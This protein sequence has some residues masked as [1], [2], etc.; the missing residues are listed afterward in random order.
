MFN[1]TSLT[2]LTVMTALVFTA[3]PA[4]GQVAP[5]TGSPCYDGSFQSGID[6]AQSTLPLA[7]NLSIADIILRIIAVILDVIL[8]IA[9]L[10][11]IIAGVYLIMSGGD[12]GQKDKAKKIIIYV[13]AGIIV[14]LFA[15]AIVIFVNNAFT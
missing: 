9:V 13:I 4:L 12:E 14:I 10:A 5:C 1:R 7:A 3:T 11:V 6:A 2:L 8:L 15:R